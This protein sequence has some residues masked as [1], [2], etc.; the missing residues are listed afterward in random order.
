MRH[1]APIALALWFALGPGVRADTYPRQP[2][3]DVQHYRFQLTLADETDRLTG[4]ATIVIR[5]T[6]PGTSTV[7]L[8]L[9]GPAPD[10]QGKGMVVDE[11]TA[12]ETPVPFRHG[13]DRLELSLAPAPATGGET[14]TFTVRYHGVPADGLIVS[15]NTY[16]DRTFFADNFPD[17]ARHWLPVVDHPSDKATCEFLVTTPGRYRTIATGLPVEESDLPDGRRLSHWRTTV[18]VPTYDMVIGVAR[19]AVQYVDRRD[20]LSIETWAFP[21]ARDGWFRAFAVTPH[22]LDYVSYLVGPYP[23]EKLA[24]VQ[25]RTRYGGMENAGNIFYAQTLAVERGVEGIAAHEI[26][27]QWFG[28][29][30]TVADWNHVWLS[31]G[32]AT[33]LEHL[34]QAATHGHQRLVEAMANDRRAVLAYAAEHPDAR[35]VDP[36]EPVDRILNRYSYQKGAWVLHMLRRRVGD[37]AFVAGIREYYRRFRDA[38]ALTDDFRRVLQEVS[39][40]DL[41]GFF[42]QWVYGP[43]HPRVL[44]TWGY[45]LARRTLDVQIDQRQ[46]GRP[47]IF[48]LDLGLTFA[49]GTRRVE[50]VTVSER[51]HRA[52]LSLDAPPVAVTLDPDVWLLAELD[53]TRR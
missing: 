49:D 15:A 1:R 39:G 25:S 21:Q 28:N 10:R 45:D 53:V 33:Y 36:R 14:R 50:T 11:V 51:T 29:A 16:G 23:Y 6:G 5:F 30:V 31:E 27:H 35:V 34:Y 43:G 20:G 9:A 12:G 37:E 46:E 18:P 41:A 17:R 8:D 2:G 32:F 3:V 19:F 44:A 24:N 4:E 26:A 38:N 22:I 47:F 48:D 13:G 40:T 42:D 52:T 7:T